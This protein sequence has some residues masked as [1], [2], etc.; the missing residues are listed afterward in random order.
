MHVCLVQV[1]S[2]PTTWAP[3]RPDAYQPRANEMRER[4]QPRREYPLTGTRARPD[5]QGGRGT[6]TRH[7]HH[8]YLKGKRYARYKLML[9]LCQIH[10]CHCV[11]NLQLCDPANRGAV[12]T[13]GHKAGTRKGR[14]QP[15]TEDEHSEAG[16]E[17]DKPK[18]S[19]SLYT[20]SI[21]DWT[22]TP[23]NSREREDWHMS[24]S[25]CF[26]KCG[27]QVRLATDE[28]DRLSDQ[29]ST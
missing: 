21:S 25:N 11:V 9:T 10:L 15:E 18:T 16:T 2:S 7:L 6:G 19:S 8:Q 20:N 22:C 28:L 26:M 1:F 5:C 12:S 14:R 3:G 17:G 27:A 4:C 29:H 13:P 23:R 24:A